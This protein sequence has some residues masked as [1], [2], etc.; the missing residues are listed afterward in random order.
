MEINW[1]YL[2]ISAEGNEPSDDFVW[3]LINEEINAQIVKH[4][5]K[6]KSKV[7]FSAKK[8]GI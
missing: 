1:V 3:M 2:I 8:S 4:E 6:I 7:I 5:A